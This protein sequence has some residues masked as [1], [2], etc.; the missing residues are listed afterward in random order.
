MKSAPLPDNERE[1]LA[2]LR[3]YNILDTP[4]EEGFDDFTKLAAAIFEAPISL[5]SFLDEKRLWFKSTVGLPVV[6]LP[7]D[8]AFCGYAIIEKYPF[9]IQDSRADSRFSDHPL[10][11]GDPKVRFYA[12]APLITPSGH[13][14]GTLCIIDREPRKL[15]PEQSDLLQML[16]NRVMAQLEARRAAWKHRQM[17]LD[18]QASR[19]RFDLAVRGASNGFWDWDIRTGE[20][21]YSPRFKE[22]LGFEDQYFKPRVSTIMHR[23]H[24][25]DRQRVVQAFRD[26][27]LLGAPLDLECRL[28]N[29]QGDHPWFLVKGQAVWDAT[30]RAIRMVGSINDITRRKEAERVLV[31]Q[32]A[33]LREQAG[34]LNLTHDPIVVCDMN[35]AVLF[36]NHGAEIM[37]GWTTEEARG[38]NL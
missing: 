19:D 31:R 15:T 1:R 10:V 9:I 14:L 24:P 23:L 28:Q 12:G 33:T 7:R 18:L 37:Y 27:Q 17:A 3:D 20:V 36:W 26:H 11:V 4:P 38:R 8:L 25:E 6:E 16:A 32:A 22:S 13:S 29:R 21:Y 30:G 35:D 34:L 2:V 5:L